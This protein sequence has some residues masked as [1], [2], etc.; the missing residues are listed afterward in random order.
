M[1]L[2]RIFARPRD[3]AAVSDSARRN[4]WE[5]ESYQDRVVLTAGC[6]SVRYI[7]PH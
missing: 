6:E 3:N 1:S 7:I 5:V 4:I 2:W